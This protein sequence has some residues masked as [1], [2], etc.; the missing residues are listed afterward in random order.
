[1]RAATLARRL[2]F[3]SSSGALVWRL[4][5]TMG[6]ETRRGS[7]HYY[8]RSRKVNGRIIRE[9]VGSGL[10]AELAARQDAEAR[11][12]RLAERERLQHE[13]AR[14]ASASTPLKE[15]GQLL[16]GLTAATLIAAGYHQHHRGAWRKRRH[17]TQG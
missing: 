16:D 15:L 4:H 2:V 14:W 7:G 8:T 17:G 11:A 13:A 5:N 6:W 1:M 10:V 12:Q 9:Y 3:S